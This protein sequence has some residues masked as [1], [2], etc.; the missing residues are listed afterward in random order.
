MM[1]NI[2]GALEVIYVNRKQ[3]NDTFTSKPVLS[4]G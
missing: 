1:G 3:L 4:P 2:N